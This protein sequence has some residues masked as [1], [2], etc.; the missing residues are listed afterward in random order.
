MCYKARTIKNMAMK[1]IY[2]SRTK[3]LFDS[4]KIRLG[5]A[6]EKEIK[7]FETEDGKL[8][9]WEY[10]RKENKLRHRFDLCLLTELQDS[11]QSSEQQNS[12]E[13]KSRLVSEQIESVDSLDSRF[14]H[15]KNNSITSYPHQHNTSK[16]LQPGDNCKELLHCK[17]NS[18][19]SYPHKHN[20]V[21]A[22]KPGDI[23]KDTEEDSFDKYSRK[24]QLSSK[25]LKNKKAE[26][27]PENE[28]PNTEE[29]N[30][31]KICDL[32]SMRIPISFEVKYQD[33]IFGR[34]LGHSHFGSVY[35]E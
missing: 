31:K 1:L 19:T 33:V 3:G 2:N 7:S 10:A 5:L 6:N 12:C 29:L 30:N 27:T 8:G 15:S 25:T 23:F 35:N 34:E 24:E 11:S 4:S 28:K 9:L 26:D 20:T 18:S 21:K 22:L 32:Q 17:N 16:A 14:L 13:T